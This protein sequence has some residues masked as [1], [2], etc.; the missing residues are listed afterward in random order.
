LPRQPPGRR[1]RAARGLPTIAAASIPAFSTLAL[2]LVLGFSA[3]AQV[4]LQNIKFDVLSSVSGGSANLSS[5]PLD[6]GLLNNIFDGDTNS[7]AR[8]PNIN[9]AFVQVAYAQP[10]TVRRFRVFL[11]YGTSYQWWIE[12]A[13]NQPDMDGRAGSYAVVTPTNTM[14]SWTWSEYSLPTPVTANLV[15]LNVRRFGGDG[16]CHLNEWELYGDVVVDQLNITPTNS[17]VLYVGDTR[18]FQATGRNIA[19]NESYSVGDVVSW[20]VTGGIGSIS[21]NGLLTLTNAGAGTVYG[22]IGTLQSPATP[23]SVLVPNTHPDIDV[24]Y[25][26][27]TP[28]LAFDPS[29]ATYSSGLPTNGQPVT[30]LAHV[31]NWGTNAAL[32]RF[33][34]RL[35]G[36]P[37]LSGSISLGATQEVRLPFVRA[38]ETNSHTID[39]RADPDDTVTELS[40]LNNR[41]VI[42][43]DALLVGLWVEQGLHGYF[44]NTQYNLLDGANG[45]EDWGQRMVDRWNTM[46]HK[47]VF[48][49]APDGFLDWLALDQVVVVPDNALPLAGGIA[50]NNP[51]SRDRTVDMQWG[52]PWNPRTIDPG[53]F[54]GFR[55]NGP[56]FID[57]GSI[58]EMNHARYH[59]DLYA[60]DE[61]HN[62]TAQNVLLY[63]DGG[64][65]VPGSSLM[66]FIAFDV[67]YYN[68]WRDIMGAGSPV[69]EGYSAGAWNWK[70]HKRGQGNQNSP[71]DIGRFLNDL[72]ATNRFQFIDQNGL[73]VAGAEVAYYRADGG[74]YTKRFR[75]PPQDSFLTDATGTVVLP[76]NPFGGTLPLGGFGPASPDIIFKLRYRNQQYYFFQEVTDFNIQY[77]S[78]RTNDAL[79]V[80][81]LDLRDDPTVVP[82]NGWLGNYF[83]GDNFDEFVTNR[84]EGGT[85]A[86]QFNWP[87]GSPQSGVGPDHF[88][89]YWEGRVPFTEGWKTFSIETDGGIRLS[90]DG[91][92]VFDQWT[93]SSL[94][95]WTPVIYTAASSPFVHPGHSTANGAQHRLELRYRHD[96]GP[97]R[98]LL[99][100]TDEPPPDDVPLNAWRADYYTTRSLAGYM[101]SRLE[102]AIDYDY[103][104]GSPDPAVPADNFS[105]RWTGDWDLPAGTYSFKA[106]TDDGM[107]VYLD[108][109]VALDKWFDQPPTTYTFSRTFTTSG[110]RRFRVEYYEGAVTARASFGW[111]APPGVLSQPQSLTVLEGATAALTVVATG[112]PPP[113]YQWQLNKMN[114]PGATAPTLSLTDVHT[115]DTGNYRVALTNSAGSFISAPITLTVAPASAQ[116][117]FGPV[118]L[119]SDGSLQF[120]LNGAN[121]WNYRIDGTAN[122]IDWS[123]LTNVSYTNGPWLYVDRGG[124]NPRYHFY[125]A[126]IP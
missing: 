106:I 34:W 116:P 118:D 107:R 45:F 81:Q 66:P 85:N 113:T 57:F 76:R 69:F 26:E 15:K 12:K 35:D 28:R 93:N 39:F 4:T 52:Y 61:N 51:D 53:Q 90:I 1:R 24:L 37:A 91:R 115:N 126:V 50:G 9:P 59:V 60:L 100:W 2:S 112:S 88:T 63:D 23:V 89:V 74:F 38:W 67:V 7:L 20:S 104:G 41:R 84:I 68:K 86:I 14:N 92:L 98:A 36:A 87:G 119:L 75:E 17:Q 77:W 6:L 114:I 73:P 29:D 122:L 8:T 56:F 103:Q 25:I 58:H 125:R 72:P 3:R 54:Y 46:M 19:A 65:L 101:I 18:L 42:R 40:K 94:Q 47:T 22:A 102:S 48:P 49:F 43:S 21:S 108:D 33:E 111:T 10:R 64:A 13:D 5:T 120:T 124:T 62:D 96:S 78:G 97:A 121:G 70:H 109:V 30:W 117:G 27:R 123:P 31:K 105:A 55:W 80:R 32:V 82:T 44:H 11:S 79:Y 71:P 110:R 99:A 16:Y 95:A 83:N